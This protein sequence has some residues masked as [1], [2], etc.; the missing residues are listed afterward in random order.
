MG[1]ESSI[2][3]SKGARAAAVP[4]FLVVGSPAVGKSR[5]SHALAGRFPLS[6][7]IPVDD[8]RNL[9][10]SGIA[11]PAAVWSDELVR[12]VTLA[13]ATAARMARAY[14]EASFAVVLD[15]FLD[16]DHLS[17]YQPLLGHRD[18]CKVVPF[19]A[20]EAA[21]ERNRQRCGTEPCA[22]IHRR[23]A[24][25]RLQGVR[26]KDPASRAAGMARC[27]HDVHGCGGDGHGASAAGKVRRRP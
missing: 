12:Q 25:H 16:S 2:C 4:I 15:E 7:H 3:A 27:R 1:T 18:L 9:V 5:T 19:P 14:H 22:R 23:G 20:Q 6:I 26:C 13:R 11:L 24:A 21:L 8:L 17:G 10:V